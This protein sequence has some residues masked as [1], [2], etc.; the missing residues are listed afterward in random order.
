[1]GDGVDNNTHNHDDDDDLLKPIPRRPYFRSAKKKGYLRP[2]VSIVGLGCSSFSNFFD[3]STPAA[4]DREQEP[5]AGGRSVTLTNLR[6]DDP[7]VQGWIETIH[8]AIR[9]AGITLLDTAP[10]YGHGVSET[11]V[12][13]ALA[14]LLWT[15]PPPSDGA[16]STVATAA[17]DDHDG[18]ATAPVVTATATTTSTTRTA[19][20][21]TA[22]ID[23]NNNNNNQ[24]RN[25]MQII[26]R[27]D[28]TINTKVGRYEADPLHMFDFRREMT[29]RSARRSLARLRIDYV[30][31][32]QL[33]DPEYAPTLDLLLDETIPALLACRDQ[34]GL[35]RAIGLTGYPLAVQHQILQASIARFGTN[36]WDHALTYAHYNLHD[37]SLVTSPLFTGPWRSDHYRS[38]DDNGDTD[39]ITT[40]CAMPILSAAPLSMG[41]LTR[42]GPPLWHPAPAA[43]KE[44]CRAAAQLC[45][46]T[47]IDIAHLAI[48]FAVQEERIPCTI[49]GLQSVAQVQTMQRIVNRRCPVFW[50]S[51]IVEQD[52]I[53]ALVL[54]TR[55]GPFFAHGV[56]REWD[57]V[58][59][60][61][62]F[63]ESLAAITT[64]DGYDDG[65]DD[66]QPFF[67]RWQA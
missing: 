8:Y 23:D 57:G 52:L 50:I 11:V 32:L 55:N 3:T 30:D 17:D 26:R 60:V 64:T 53:D 14:E 5:A 48:A 45:D 39:D 44:A 41:L 34:Y 24:Q 65:N 37:Q 2:D 35:C 40:T 28:L 42:A 38:D 58:E 29:I 1:M 16:A 12:G 46:D 20:T 6:R 66:G 36:V 4:A 15:P 22:I 49:L 33:H 19:T 51:N 61:R 59:Q 56:P 10:W 9:V 67:V 13:W 18:G 21:T 47:S 43:L 27:S 63:W 31:V 54:E 25:M 7:I 62:L